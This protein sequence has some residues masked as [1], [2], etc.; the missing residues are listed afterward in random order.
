MVWIIL[1]IILL[2]LIVVLF[3]PVKLYVSYIDKKPEVILK[4]LFIKKDLLLKKEKKKPESEKKT[5]E[6]DDSESEK[7]K[8]KKN[9]LLPDSLSGKIEFI[10]NIASTGGKAFRSLTKHLKIKDIFIDIKI[11]DLDAY[12]CALKF[13]K[14]NILVFNTLS[15]LGYFV[16][17]KKKSINIRCVYNEPECIY[18]AGCNARLTPAAAIMI[19]LAFIFRFLVNNI[20]TNQKMKKE[21]NI[22]KQNKSCINQQ[23]GE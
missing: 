23:N 17:L 12:E 19:A 1:G 6:F 5:S 4:Y 3:S 16:K 8:K 10:K 11:S 2:I 15:Y 7:D 20:K 13:G 9:K 22:K 18:N 14:T 21:A